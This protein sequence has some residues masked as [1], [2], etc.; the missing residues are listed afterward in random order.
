[1][2]EQ[3]PW[4]DILRLGLKEI[5]HEFTAVGHVDDVFWQVHA[6]MAGDANLKNGGI[7]QE[8]ITRTYTDSVAIRLRRIGD[9]R[10]DTVSLWRFLE[11]LKSAEGRLTRAWYK[12]M[13]P[14][15]LAHLAST[16][17]DHL[18]GVGARYVSREVISAKQLELDAALDAADGFANERIAHRRREPS[19]PS[20][21]FSD[22]RQCLAASFRVFEWCALLIDAAS[23]ETP[24][25][26]LQS[27]WLRVFRTPW[28]PPGMEVPEYRHL[29]YYRRVD[30]S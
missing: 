28:L 17:F 13:W 29:D 14:P 15:D 1:M 3:V 26:M 23:W 22:I 16:R 7:F 12:A 8:W 24:V 25:P 27:N 4:D 18:A 2:S 9:R 5:S 20:P 30:Q 10:K 19:L 21:K 11:E 6:I